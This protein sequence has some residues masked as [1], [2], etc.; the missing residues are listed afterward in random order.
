MSRTITAL[1]DTRADAEAA[2]NRL[3]AASLEVSHVDI[4]DKTS[5]GYTDNL[6]TGTTSPESQGFWASLKGAFSPGE[7]RHVYEEGVRR[8]G[9]L[10]TATVHDNDTDK[11]VDI[12]DNANS[13]DIDGR[14]NDWK[15]SG[16]VAPVAASGMA[17]APIA[18]NRT[19]GANEEMIPVVEETLRV[20]KRE[21]ERGGVRVRSYIVETPVS[22]QVTLR[23]EHVSVE[24]R[25]VSGG[26]VPADAFR[27]R[28]IEMTETDEEAVV[29]KDARVVEEV[30]VRKTA[31]DRTE[32]I[33]DTVRRT[34]VEVDNVAG[35]D[36]TR[37]AMTGSTTAGVG[38]GDKIAGLAKE[39]AGKM[40]GNDELERR[41]EV[42]QGKTAI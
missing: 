41:G 20:G 5:T 4:T 22:E 42:Q 34:E 32:T 35:T 24:R 11:A 16:W 14:A 40:T 27:E 29:A 13:V 38:L 30:V 23:D 28:T 26:A 31:E 10:L 1:F 25:P 39:G 3:E 19:T 21:V 15:Q 17:A 18:G 8:G 2:K 36:T 9:A 7:D 12:L 33:S 6:G 37:G